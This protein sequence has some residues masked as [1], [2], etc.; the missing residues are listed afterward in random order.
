MEFG[1]SAQH[2]RTSLGLGRIAI[3]ITKVTKYPGIIGAEPGKGGIGSQ[4]RCRGFQVGG[5]GV[6]LLC[7]SQPPDSRSIHAQ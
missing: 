3:V 6:L 4:R 5:N 2:P 7:H 1:R